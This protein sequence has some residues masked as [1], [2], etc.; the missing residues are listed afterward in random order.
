MR[1]I[2]VNHRYAPFVGGSERWIQ[3]ISESLVSNGHSVAVV[4]TDAFDLEYFWDSRRQRAPAE[5]SEQLRGVDIERVPVRHLPLSS[6]VFRGGR[7]MMGEASLVPLPP[8]I[9]RAASNTQ[10][11]LP[12]MTRVL[13]RKMP[14]DLVHATNIGIES[15]AIKAMTAAREHGIPFVVTPF[16]HLGVDGDSTARRYVSMPHQREVLRAADAVIVMTETERAF[17]EDICG[18]TRNITVAGAGVNIPEVTE[19][20]GSRFRNEL[21]ATGFLVGA[22]GAMA[23]DKGTMDLAASVIE[24]R[25]QGHDVQLALAG[26]P[27]QSFV[28]WFTALSDTDR[29]G[30]HVLGFVSAELKRDMLAAIDVMALPSRTESFG[31]VYLEAWANGVAVVAADTPATRELVHHETTGLLVPFGCRDAIAASLLRLM[32]EPEE[33]TRFGEAGRQETLLK[34]TWSHVI[35]RVETVY[36]DVTGVNLGNLT[37]T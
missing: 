31:I 14:A 15:L 3:E 25:R 32:R 18:S 9:F 34:H 33:R 36:T 24:L 22:I 26:P 29:A 30:I 20:D 27:L 1:F 16:I 17:V 8:A 12:E 4:T 23:G 35:D 5:R 37:T 7:R 21:P 6:L 19:G 13:A 28:R 11:W 2:H 10:P